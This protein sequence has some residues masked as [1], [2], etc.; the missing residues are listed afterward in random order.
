MKHVTTT[1]L[2]LA[3]VAVTGVAPAQAFFN[4]GRGQQPFPDRYGQD[5]GAVYDWAKV[6]RVDPV[7][8]SRYGYANASDRRNCTTR[9]ST[10]AGN[11]GYYDND[12]YYNGAYR[13][14][15]DYRNDR[16][17]PYDRNDRYGN[18][19]SQTGNTV[20]TVIGGIVGAAIGSQVGGG[21]ARYAT[22]AI[23]TMVGSIAGREIYQASQRERYPDGVVTVCDPVSAN[24]RYGYGGDYQTGNQVGNTRIGNNHVTGYDVTYQYAGRQFHTRTDYHPGDRIRVRVD[25]RPE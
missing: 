18:S 4:E 23:G 15:G 21:S 17:D 13:G 8:G 22:S 5:S 19:G 2:A 10:Y 12:D 7:I 14:N 16:Y 9:R 11:D 20:A 25:V 24:S 3:L 1:L 6:I